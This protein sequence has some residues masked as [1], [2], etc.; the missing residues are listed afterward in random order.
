M[1]THKNKFCDYCFFFPLKWGKKHLVLYL[2][3][4]QKEGLPCFYSRVFLNFWNPFLHHTSL[5]TR[6]IN[7]KLKTKVSFV[8]VFEILSIFFWI[9]WKIPKMPKKIEKIPFFWKTPPKNLLGGLSFK[10]ISDPTNPL[11]T[12]LPV[13][14]WKKKK[15]KQKKKQLTLTNTY[16]ARPNN[17]HTSWLIIKIL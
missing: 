3:S 10:K 7:G 15:R 11:R 5:E 1:A 2:S 16:Y 14:G 17:M 6:K 4:R 9:F 12:R 13:F 8:G